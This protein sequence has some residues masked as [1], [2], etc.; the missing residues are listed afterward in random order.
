MEA[1]FCLVEPPQN[2]D[3][4]N[5]DLRTASGMSSAGGFLSCSLVFV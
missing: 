2:T 1:H 5:M 4:R 3:L